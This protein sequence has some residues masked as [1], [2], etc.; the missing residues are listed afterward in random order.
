MWAPSG[1]KWTIIFLTSIE[2]GDPIRAW[3]PSDSNS[4]LLACTYKNG[5]VVSG[6][7]SKCLAP[8]T[9]IA[10]SLPPGCVDKIRKVIAESGTRAARP[11]ACRD[12]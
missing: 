12:E 6:D 2:N 8:E 3:A 1:E 11:E 5:R 7:A 4:E 10:K 9:L